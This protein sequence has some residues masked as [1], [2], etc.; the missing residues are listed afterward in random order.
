MW[1]FEWDWY[2]VRS[3]SV[4]VDNM[5]ARSSKCMCRNSIMKAKTKAFDTESLAAMARSWMREQFRVDRG[6]SL[7]LESYSSNEEWYFAENVRGLCATAQ[8]CIRAALRGRLFLLMISPHSSP[9]PVQVL[10]TLCPDRGKVM[11]EI[12][13]RLANI[14]STVTESAPPVSG[15]ISICILQC[16]GSHAALMCGAGPGEVSSTSVCRQSLHRLDGHRSIDL[17]LKCL[18]RLSC[19]NDHT[20]VGMQVVQRLCDSKERRAESAS[21]ARGHVSG[22]Q[23]GAP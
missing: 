1:A 14:C 5:F 23:P 18:H 12:V 13:Q 10:S 17:L 16:F 9:H 22:G 15:A 21:R 2:Q 6:I 11:V 4:K 20:V 3:L 7:A 19:K 8:V